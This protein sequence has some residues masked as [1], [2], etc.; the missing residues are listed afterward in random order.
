MKTITIQSNYEHLFVAY[1]R[2]A[3]TS[4]GVMRYGCPSLDKERLERWTCG[5]NERAPY[6]DENLQCIVY[7]VN[8]REIT[9]TC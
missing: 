9:I 3:V 1:E 2:I 6:Y 8:V 7:N 5:D 4:N